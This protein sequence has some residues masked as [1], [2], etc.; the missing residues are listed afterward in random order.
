MKFR[1]TYEGRL[2]SSG[3]SSGKTDNKQEIRRQLH[4]QLKRLWK[5]D[6][7]LSNWKYN[8]P[9]APHTPGN[10]VP[11]ADH[12]ATQNHRHGFRYI[13]LV[14]DEF[15]LRVALEILFLRTAQPGGVIRS[16]DIDGRLKTLFDGLK[17]P[18][19]LSELGKLNTPQ[20]DEDPFFVLL[21]DD[22]LVTHVSVETDTLLQPTP[23]AN[24]NFL[25]NDAR[26]VITATV[27]PC[28]VW[29]N[30]LRFV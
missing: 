17:M 23:T 15:R 4:P 20:T 30:N 18:A 10:A 24:G 22:N 9:K 11:Y 19:S 14:S 7:R 8:D 1:L 16:G 12:A 5:V 6:P 25:D 21:A 29:M 3:N 26:V 27:A 13:P 2:E 28:E